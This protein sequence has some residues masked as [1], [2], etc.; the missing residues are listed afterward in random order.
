MRRKSGVK[1][2]MNVVPFIDVMLVLLVALMLTPLSTTSS[3]NVNLPKLEVTQD[4]TETHVDNS[5]IIITVGEDGSLFLTA[6]AV[7]YLDKPHSFKEAGKLIA[8]AKSTTPNLDVIVRAD[9]DTKY[10]TV[11]SVMNLAKN[12]GVENVNLATD[13]VQ[14]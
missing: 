9:G 4:S 1:G 11:A 12:A 6:P 10:Q 14:L 13:E 8:S 2:D 3:I 7:G 5:K